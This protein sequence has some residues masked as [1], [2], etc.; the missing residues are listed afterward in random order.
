MLVSTPIRRF[1]VL[2]N[3]ENRRLAFFQAAL[4]RFGLAPA[5]VV[6]YLDFLRGRTGL[7]LAPGSVLRIESPGE[8]FEVEKQL[9]AFG[10]DQDDG[11]GL[12]SRLSRKD[13]LRLSFDRGRIRHTAQWFSGFRAALVKIKEQLAETGAEVMNAPEDILTMFD[14]RACHALLQTAGIPVPPALDRVNRFEEILEEMAERGWS[15]VFIKPVYGSSASG[16]VALAQHREQ[17]VAYTSVEVVTVGGEVKLYNSL[18]LRR[19]EEPSQIRLLVDRLCRDGVHVEKWI[20]KAAIERHSFDLR[21]VVIGEQATH[22]VVRMSSFPITN[23]HL[24][25][26]RGD[27]A[28][29]RQRIGPDKW[30]EAMHTCE[31][32]L[33][34]VPNSHYAGIDLAIAAG[35]QS[36]A[37]LE[38]NAF[39]DLLPNVFKDGLDTYAAEVA[40][41]CGMLQPLT[42]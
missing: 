4:A 26:R 40:S 38:M 3:P 27:I 15:R 2:C 42:A 16:V 7:A 30:E 11:D 29:L 34:V 33:K 25:N 8:N 22:T 17:M 28:T 24:G 19:Y 35:F 36:H 20:P 31:E 39:G 9:L 10:A 37:I 12:A 13:A 6:S 1:V 23:L 18:R 5:E 21:V 14:K 32:A 41:F